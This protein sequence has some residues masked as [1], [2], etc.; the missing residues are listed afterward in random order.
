M[1]NLFYLCNE[2]ARIQFLRRIRSRHIV[3][4][5]LNLFR[6]HYSESSHRCYML[7]ATLMERAGQQIG[8]VQSSEVTL[9]LEWAKHRTLLSSIGT[10]IHF[11]FLN[12]VT[13]AV[14]G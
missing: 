11:E 12:R 3:F 2:L 9:S 8:G 1:R 10:I 6:H 7:T 14:V 4:L 5:N 13:S